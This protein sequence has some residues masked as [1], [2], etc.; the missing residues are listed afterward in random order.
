VHSLIGYRSRPLLGHV[1]DMCQKSWC[2]SCGKR[3]FSSQRIRAVISVSPK[4]TQISNYSRSI[5][6]S[7]RIVSNSNVHTSILRYSFPSEDFN[8]GYP[9]E[10]SV[11]SA[12]TLQ[13][14]SNPGCKV[15]FPWPR[16]KS[17]ANRQVEQGHQYLEMSQTWVALPSGIRRCRLSGRVD[18]PLP[19]WSGRRTRTLF[20]AEFS[21]S[22]TGMC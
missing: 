12:V 17:I 1:L 22:Y 5:Q 20:P 8:K 13:I 18:P 16:A 15:F 7:T 3:T 4:A 9:F 14:T 11:K 2:Q 10:H 6:V 19:D 21:R